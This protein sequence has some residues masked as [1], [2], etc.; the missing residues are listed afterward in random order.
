M[1]AGPGPTYAPPT[2]A[3]PREREL[4]RALPTERFTA[5][6]PARAP[7]T[8]AAFRQL[9]RVPVR[10]LTASHCDTSRDTLSRPRRAGATGSKS[11]R[12]VETQ[13]PAVRSSERP[14]VEMTSLW[15]TPQRATHSKRPA[16]CPQGLGQPPHAIEG[17]HRLVG[18]PHS[19]RRYYRPRSPIRCNHKVI[20]V[21]GTGGCSR[22]RSPPH[23]RRSQS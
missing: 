14:P 23:L 18:C 22:R 2:A 17:P 9:P 7:P 21:Y 6:R 20:R 19:H 16:G 4:S 3:G 1:S 15:T 13:S 11:R 10:S 5:R 12:T 8:A